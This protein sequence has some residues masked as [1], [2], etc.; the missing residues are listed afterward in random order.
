MTFP[1]QFLICNV[2]I[3]LFLG[4]FLLFKKILHKQI[5]PKAHYRLW[6]AFFLVLIL[7]FIPHPV[8]VLENLFSKIPV[9][10]SSALHLNPVPSPILP[11][12]STPDF[13]T[14]GAQAGMFFHKT[15]WNIWLI[16][17]TVS[18]L[19]LGWTVIRIHFLK[20]EAD[21]VTKKTEPELHRL[22][23]SCQ[24]E[25]R[26]RRNV[27]LYASR[28]L[29][30]PVSCGWLRPFVIIPRDLDI[31]LS[32]PEIRYI[33]LHELQHY[34]HKD[35]IINDL[36][37]FMQILYWFNPFIRYGFH[38]LQRDRE[39]AC[40]Q[41]VI[42]AIGKEHRLD[43]SRTLLKY[44]WQ[45]KNGMYRIYKPPLS[46]L[47]G[48][49]NMLK[50][51]VLAI[52]D[53]ERPSILKKIKALLAVCLTLLLACVFSPL[54]RAYPFQNASF[55]FEHENW[56][57]VDASSYFGGTDGAFV[58]Y[59]IEKDQF[60]IYNQTL[61]Q[62][63][64]APYS[65][66]KIYSGLFALEEKIISPESSLQ[67]WDGTLWEYPKWN[68]DQTLDTAMKNSVNWYFQDL[69]RQMG[70]F[71]LRSYYNRISYGNGD[72]SGGVHSYWAES[73]LKI[74]PLEQVILLS[75]LLQNKWKF[76]AENIETIKDSLFLADTPYGKLYGKTGTGTVH[77]KN[78]SG[79]FVGFLEQKEHTCCFAA[80][81]QNSPKATG[82]DAAKIVMNILSNMQ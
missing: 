13:P 44:A 64:I 74:S 46:A 37:C 21:L 70:I 63:R 65:T 69:D 30:N 60:Q 43:Y 79:W 45:K 54:L 3:S 18:A 68:R 80:N 8:Y 20:K 9:V 15:L 14:A 73:S 55:S 28:R 35:P 72:L 39:M 23:R 76:Q 4:I 32:M 62:K 25:L 56:E 6:L 24:K 41:G 10:A 27:R 47:G 26:I 52:A 67:E 75:D 38:C 11:N 53:Y 19:F 12:W 17:M 36:V 81:L 59:D 5:T 66:F 34:K 57:P 2:F 77:G 16:G 61:S 48:N 7:P 51:R 31:R 22:Y 58:L 42:R 49:H 29:A 82:S 33:L 78:V 40:D 1:L 71:K 50:Q